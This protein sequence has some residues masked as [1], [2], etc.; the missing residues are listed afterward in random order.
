MRVEQM[1]YALQLSY[2]RPIGAKAPKL[3]SGLEWL[4]VLMRNDRDSYDFVDF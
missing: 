2:R 1:T 4:C 3:G